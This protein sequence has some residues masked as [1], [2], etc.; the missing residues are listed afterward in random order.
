MFQVYKKGRYILHPDHCPSTY[1][2]CRHIYKISIL[3]FY[4]FFLRVNFLSFLDYGPNSNICEVYY[5]FNVVVACIC[6]MVF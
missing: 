5:D 1:S 4:F 3:G 6:H 2:K